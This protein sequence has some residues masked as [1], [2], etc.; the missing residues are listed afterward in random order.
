MHKKQKYILKLFGAILSLCG[1]CIA[2]YGI[3]NILTM[4]AAGIFTFVA[5]LVLMN[6]GVKKQEHDIKKGERVAFPNKSY[7][8]VAKI[9]FFTN[10]ILLL[11][12]KAIFS[13]SFGD[14]LSSIISFVL[15]FIISAL[16][17]TFILTYFRTTVAV[18]LVIAI[19]WA[20]LIVQAT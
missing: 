12:L 7:E 2:L 15:V 9:I 19:T 13:I 1:L 18:A 10:L 11:Y 16:Y 4:P 6:I 8:I 17:T 3:F 5:G 20:G 14:E